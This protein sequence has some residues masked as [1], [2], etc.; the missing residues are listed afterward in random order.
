MAE[1][2]LAGDLGHDSEVV[3]P[4]LQRSQHVGREVAS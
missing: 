4:E 2:N 3:L 1:T